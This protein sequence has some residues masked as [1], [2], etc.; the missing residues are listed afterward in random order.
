MDNTD[1]YRNF[2]T[3]KGLIS[4]KLIELLAR[5]VRNG[6]ETRDYYEIFVHTTKT[7]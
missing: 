1:N 7:F 5:K 3:R 4:S 2:K 6:I